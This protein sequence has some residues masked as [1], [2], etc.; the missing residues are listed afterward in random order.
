[1]SDEAFRLQNKVGRLA[2][3]RG[4]FLDKDSES[5]VETTR[6]EDDTPELVRRS[7]SGDKTAFGL[8][9]RRNRPA[10]YRLAHNYLRADAEDAVAETFARAWKA[11]P[12]YRDRG[13]PFAAWLYGIA[14]NVVKDELRRKSRTEPRAEFF[15]AAVHHPSEDGLDLLAAIGRLSK[16]HRQVVEMKYLMG[17]DNEAIAKTLGKSTGA[18]NAMRWRAL[19]ELRKVVER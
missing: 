2:N 14:R 8:L 15:D 12:R 5:H 16:Q 11:L 3:I 19:A 1:M 17:L 7:Q 6:V 18:V 10:V 13:V 4:V 9:Y